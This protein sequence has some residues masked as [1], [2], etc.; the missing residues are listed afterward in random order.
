MRDLLLVNLNVTARGIYEIQ[1]DKLA[2]E[3]TPGGRF[4]HCAELKSEAP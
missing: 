1:C 4:Q 3:V 2:N